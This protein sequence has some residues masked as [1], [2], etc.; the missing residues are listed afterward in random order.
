MTR[1]LLA[2]LG[3]AMLAALVL[4][5]LPAAADDPGDNPPVLFLAQYENAATGKCLDI[6]ERGDINGS[7]AVQDNCAWALGFDEQSVPRRWP[8]YFLVIGGFVPKCLEVANFSTANGAPAAQHDCNTGPH[9]QWRYLPSGFT[10]DTALARWLSSSVM[11]QN[12][13]SGKCLE[14]ASSSPQDGA[15]IVQNDCYRGLNQLWFIHV[16]R[17]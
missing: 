11:L 8:N 3:A 1:R 12:V 15:A 10:G 9:Q 5:A 4:P 14:V 7:P 16:Y 13:Y 17:Y 6:M 2:V